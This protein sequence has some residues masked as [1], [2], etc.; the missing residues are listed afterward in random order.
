MEGISQF[1]APLID[2]RG[3]AVRAGRRQLLHDIDLTVASGEI[4]TLIGP[5]GAGKTTLIRAILGLQNLS[6]GA[7]HLR[8]RIRIGYMPQRLA[9]DPSLP[10]TAR[11]FI[12]LGGRV[13]KGKR[14]AILDEVG[15]QHIVD[16][17][18]HDLSGGEFQRVLL[19]RALM[20]DPGLLVL[21]EP[22]QA[23]DVTGQ[24][25]LYKLVA[26]IRTERG[27][28]VLMASHDLNLVM[29]STDN[30]I[31]INGHLCCAGHPDSITSDPTYMEMFGEQLAENF[32]LYQHSHDHH[33]TVDGRVIP[34][35]EAAD[36]HS[37]AQAELQFEGHRHDG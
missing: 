21:D 19:A 1:T 14:R 10:L 31:C 6:A 36:G 18:I 12:G 28:G 24:A 5:N 37:H 7:V 15:V 3:L 34:G 33:H 11:R 26:Q 25:E 16:S 4:V 32:A 30:V 13:N 23:V 9:I 20:R 29:S 8:P 17:S 2:V 35:D 27:C 22:A